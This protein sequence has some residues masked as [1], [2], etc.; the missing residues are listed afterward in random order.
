MLFK[1][2]TKILSIRFTKSIFMDL[3]IWMLG[4]GIF[5]GV[6]FPPFTYLVLGIAKHKVFS[7]VFFA[8]CVA[9]GSIVGLIN[10]GLVKHVISDRFAMLIHRMKRINHS[11]QDIDYVGQ[12]GDEECMLHLKSKDSI[13]ET[14]DSFNE[15]IMALRQRTNFEAQLWSF[16][17]IMN[18]HIELPELVTSIIREF[19]KISSIEAGLCIS[20]QRE[21]WQILQTYG[22]SLAD[23]DQDKLYGSGGLVQRVVISHKTLEIQIPDDIPI[24]LSTIGFTMRPKCMILYPVIYHN[25]ILA[26]FIFLALSPVSPETKKIM[27][28]AFSQMAN[29]FQNSMLHERV[30]KISVVDELTG[31]YNRRF[32]LKRLREELSRADRMEDHIAVVMVDLD[33]FKSV[34]DTYGHP[35]GDAVLREIA[36]IF[37]HDLRQGDIMCRWGGEEF[38]L[39]F[40]G[41][42]LVNAQEL[43][44]RLRKM[45]ELLEIKWQDNVTLRITASFGI[46]IYPQAKAMDENELISQADAA[47]YNA[48]NN[49]RNRIEIH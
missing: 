24:D 9:A 36:Q 1:M 8:S 12:C 43:T 31:A 25:N 28:A 21:K 38:L 33:H 10:F 19:C 35:A 29:A 26:I 11:L 42:S 22:L 15:L 6:V 49:G 44:E 2:I 32:G 47:L 7:W 48:K 5:M 46:A 41:A 39:I 3:L 34:N 18:K 17:Q 27:E 30:K 4:F 37:S 40:L 14:A 20:N 16:I 23:I 45:V 13:G